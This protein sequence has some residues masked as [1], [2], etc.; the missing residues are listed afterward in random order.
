MINSNVLKT[1]MMKLWKDTFHDSDDYIKLI[2]D[3]YFDIDFVECYYENDE[4]VAGLLAVPYEFDI[5]TGD[6]NDDEFNNQ[7]LS[8]L[9]LC[10]LATLPNYRKRGLMSMLIEKINQRAFE[11]GYDF[12]FLIPANESLVKYYSSRGYVK[13]FPR[14]ENVYFKGENFKYNF[15]NQFQISGEYSD[16][17]IDEKITELDDC[18]FEVLDYSNY[19]NVE[20]V[21][22]FIKSV[23]LNNHCL[24]LIHTRRD[25]LIAIKENQISNGRVFVLK[26][27]NDERI[28]AV[29]F[30]SVDDTIVSGNTKILKEG[31][32]NIEKIIVTSLFAI[33]DL[34][35]CKLLHEINNHYCNLQSM[36]VYESVYVGINAKETN[37]NRELQHTS[38]RLHDVANNCCV[39]EN[40]RSHGMLRVLN[41][42]N[43]LKFL[44]GKSNRIKKSILVGDCILQNETNF[45]ENDRD[46]LFVNRN[47]EKIITKC[48]SLC[49]NKADE[50]SLQKVSEKLLMCQDEHNSVSDSIINESVPVFMTLMLD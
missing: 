2:F 36:T 45:V 37:H 50:I 46:M 25:L 22:S 42:P 4:L 47:F 10:G 32:I 43:I 21:L 26:N 27:N 48:N 41:P 1:R 13:S 9:Y 16:I 3:N 40:V 35:R 30:V 39:G 28:L 38:V 20:F 49:L 24:S 12:T 33:N 14:R 18:I 8:G 5:L 19:E 29:A 31:I 6:D 34:S 23:E 11:K 7:R 44:S 17:V 15:N